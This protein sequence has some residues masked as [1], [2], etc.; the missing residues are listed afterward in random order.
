MSDNFLD[1]L[2]DALE[3]DEEDE[4]KADA[5]NVN[6]ALGDDEEYWSSR[7]KASKLRDLAEK[8]SDDDDS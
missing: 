2:D 7:N 6:D 3:S 1:K 8:K 5:Q 4:D